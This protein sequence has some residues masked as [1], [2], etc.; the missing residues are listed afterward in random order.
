[1]QGKFQTTVLPKVGH[2]VHEDSPA[3][4]ADEV[5]RFAARYRF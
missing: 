1:M 3:H 4:L 5:A 2:A